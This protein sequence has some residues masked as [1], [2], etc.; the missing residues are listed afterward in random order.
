M[1]YRSEETVPNC[2]LTK[3][4]HGTGNRSVY[5][6]AEL[7]DIKTDQL[8]ISATLDYI[9]QAVKERNYILGSK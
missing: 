9:L 4:H 8:M 7:R 6:Y 3:V 5:I 1:A 2:Y